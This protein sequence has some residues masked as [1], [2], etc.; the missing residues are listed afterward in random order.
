MIHKVL[1]FTCQNKEKQETVS[2]CSSRPRLR[3][4]S[5]CFYLPSKFCLRSVK[6]LGKKSGNTRC[7]APNTKT[8][9]IG[10][11]GMR[12]MITTGT[13]VIVSLNVRL[14]IKSADNIGRVTHVKSQRRPH[15]LTSRSAPLSASTCSP[16]TPSISNP[17]KRRRRPQ[18][19]SSL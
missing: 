13:N 2:Y 16:A 18:T 15:Q 6:Q 19:A 4:K 3:F 17:N 12:R 1:M 14:G 11:K 7:M 8:C 5:T 9:P 10:D